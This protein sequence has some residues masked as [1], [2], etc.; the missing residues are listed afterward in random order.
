MDEQLQ[1]LAV[2]VPSPVASSKKGGIA[3][4]F[5][6]QSSHQAIVLRLARTLSGLRA[7]RVLLDQGYC[8]EQAAICRMVNEF[9]DD[10]TFLALASMEEIAPPILTR[11]LE[12]FFAPESSADQYR[13]GDRI[14][15]RPMV[16]RKDILNYI[17][18]Q[19]MSE[20]D[21]FG[22]SNAGL[23]ISFAFSGY[24][25]GAAGHTMEMF[26]PGL[27]MFSSKLDKGHP[28]RRAHED[29][30]WNYYF[31]GILAFGYAALAMRDVAA[32]R[33]YQEFRGVFEAESG[34]RAPV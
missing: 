27:D 12:G 13:V 3:F 6:E 31:R 4:S 32:Q 23:A 19:S 24:V 2:L 29:D 7:A 14:K 25:H 22:H 34:D 10:V 9:Q 1:R 8:Q 15:G 18:R 33:D 20:V 17:A 26:D 21:Q 16:S 5:A 28:L 11:Y 30:I